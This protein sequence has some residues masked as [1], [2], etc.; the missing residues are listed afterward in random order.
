[1]SYNT[2]RYDV[3]DHI[4]T[5]TLDRPDQ[6]NAFTVEMAGELIDA[7]NRASDDDA[8]RAIVITGAGKGF[9]AG[10]DLKK[11]STGE[12]S[13]AERE[14]YIR[15]AHETIR[16]I[17]EH[18]KPII[19]AV[20]GPAVGAGVNLALVCDL[21]LAARSARFDSRFIKLGIHPGG[22]HTWMLRQLVGPQT[23]A[24]MSMFN[25]K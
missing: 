23:A 11:H 5:L 21:R 18:P 12:R 13:E 22:G 2:L 20:N 1:M 6:L 7:F 19:A 24:A 10:A 3:A 15:L 14:S 17:V 16:K 4:L 25:V 9:C 8:V